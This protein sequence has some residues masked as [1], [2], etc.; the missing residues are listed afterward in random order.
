MP[1]VTL[2][3]TPPPPERVVARIGLIAD[4]HLPDRLSA[5]PD[6]LGAA[7]ADVELILHAGDVGELRV[8]DELSAIAPVL[9]V[10]GNDD[11]IAAQR[12]LP[13]QQIVS[14]AGLRLLLTHAHYPDRADELASRRE[15][16]WAPKLERRAAM[17]RRAGAPIVVFGHTHVPMTVAWGDTLLVNPGAIAPGTHFARPLIAAVARVL[18]CADGAVAVEHID[19][20]DPRRTFTPPVDLEAGFVAAIGQ[21]QASILA[22]DMLPLRSRVGALFRPGGLGR[23]DADAVREVLS[24]LAHPCWAGERDLITRAEFEAAMRRDLPAGLWRRAMEIMEAQR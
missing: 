2:L 9:A 11:T 3:T 18:I 14:V 15:D 17:G 21:V 4:T 6:T 1:A 5:L 13:Y 8:L 22:D 12:E 16:R 23:D 10:H 20:R 7:F 19:L 24:R